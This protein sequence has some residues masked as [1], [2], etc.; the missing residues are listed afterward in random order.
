MSSAGFTGLTHLLSSERSSTI[1][2]FLR[3]VKSFFVFRGEFLPGI[4]LFPLLP[5]YAALSLSVTVIRI[6]LWS[7]YSKPRSSASAL[8]TST[9]GD[10]RK[11]SMQ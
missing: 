10:T 2:D 3:F 4:F 8:S 5:A 9:F 11:P 6:G 7:E 1:V